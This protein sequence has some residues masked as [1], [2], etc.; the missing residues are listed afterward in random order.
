MQ[1]STTGAVDALAYIVV[2]LYYV[3]LSLV[4]GEISKILM[5]L[6][7]DN[8]LIS[9]RPQIREA[10]YLYTLVFQPAC[11]AHFYGSATFDICYISNEVPATGYILILIKTMN[12]K[13]D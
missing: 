2:T 13:L 11:S 4:F 1:A 12:L 3:R 5:E 10:R 7:S 9:P 6:L 8:R